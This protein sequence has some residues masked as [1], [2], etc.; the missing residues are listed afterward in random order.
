MNVVCSFLILTFL[1]G[2]SF[3]C[4]CV[5]FTEDQRLCQSD[6]AGVVKFI[7]DSTDNCEETDKC[8][9]ISILES[10]KGPFSPNMTSTFGSSAACGISF[11][12]TSG[13]YLIAGYMRYGGMSV[14]LNI[15]SYVLKK[16]FGCADQIV[17]DAKTTLK[18]C[19]NECNCGK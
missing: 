7:G 17:K 3:A 16:V 19:P 9:P 11:L 13:E 15:C 1:V 4:S 12:P 18:N 6:F 14:N 8:R 5:P 10:L 2:A